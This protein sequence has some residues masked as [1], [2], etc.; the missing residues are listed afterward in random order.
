MLPCKRAVTYLFVIGF[1][2]L[3]CTACATKKARSPDANVTPDL[4]EVTHI[5]FRGNERFRSGQLRKVMAIKSRP[6]VP[7]WKRGDLYNE[8]TV[9]ADLQ[10]LKKFYFDR[11]FLDATVQLGEVQEDT[12]SRTVRLDIIIEEGPATVLQE[13]HIEGT[14]PSELLPEPLLRQALPLQPG[15]TLTKAAFD[16]SRSRLLLHMQNAGYARAQVVP[17]T[18]VDFASHR[19]I[20]T[21]ILQPGTLTSFGRVTIQGAKR[22]SERTIRRKLAVREGRIYNASALSEST[23]AVYELGMFQA[24]T[25]RALNFDDPEAP[26]DV[27]FEVRERKPRAIGFGIG[28]STV[29][30]LRFQIRWL[31]RNLFGGAQQLEVPLKVSGVEQTLEPRLH[32][33]YFLARRTTL[34]M[35]LFLRNQQELNFA[36]FGLLDNLFDIQDPHPAFDLFSAGGEARVERQFTRTLSGALGS[37]LSLNDFRRVDP[38]AVAELGEAAAEDNIL[39]TQFAEVR[40]NTSDSLLN[41]TRGWL[42]RSKI[43]HATDAF[44]SDVSFAKVEVEVRHYLRLWWQLILAT[45]LEIGGIQPYGST[46]DVPF[47]I[48]F[49]AGGPGSV[50]GFTFNRLGPL[51]ANGEPIGGNSLIEGSA[52]LRFPIIGSIG[53]ALFVDFGNVFRESFTYRLHD[54]RYAVG[55]GIRYNT[56]IGPFRFDIGFIVD[57]REGEDF[58]RFELSIGQAF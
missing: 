16:Q 4:P 40:W 29:E 45:R 47:N 1:L 3:G 10:R 18:E 48:R 32:F 51:D 27:E 46:E 41:P 35:T 52:E 17:R 2:V 58:A 12:E 9:Q 20:V 55:P 53:G 7:P 15:E 23:D 42:L 38:E 24:V 37:E 14:I 28:F 44:V 5:T 6:L 26:L 19:A 50:R 39:L 36:P 34:T 43:T 8:P 33:P 54:L 31:H 22:V 13:L 30:S 11:G 57:R 49:F 56:P 25:P 21:F